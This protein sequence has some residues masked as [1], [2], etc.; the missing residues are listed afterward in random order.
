MTGLDYLPPDALVFLDA[1]NR[2]AEKARELE[3]QLSEDVK[4]LLEA[5]YPVLERDGYLLPWREACDRLGDFSLVM[6]DAFTAGRYP[7]EPKSHFSA[8]ARQ[9]PSYG[10]S[11]E[12]AISDV[13]HYMDLDQNSSNYD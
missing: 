11:A 9:L 3:D 5:G 7:L 6:G 10:G 4:L 1:P 12:T 2:C 8:N 13:R